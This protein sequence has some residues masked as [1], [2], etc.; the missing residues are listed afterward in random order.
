VDAMAPTVAI[1]RRLGGGALVLSALFNW[2]AALVEPRSTETKAADV[3]AT[4]AAHTDRVLA[5]SVL[6]MIGT[7]L[8]LPAV[9]TIVHLLTPRAPKLAHIGGA[10]AIAGLFGFM[11][12]HVLDAALVELVKGGA[13]REQMAALYD[14]F[15]NNPGIGL[16]VGMFLV[17]QVFGFLILSI[18]LFRTRSLPRWIPPLTWVFLL[19]DV[20]CGV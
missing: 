19:W 20:G 3:L 18:G 7:V 10:M 5:S 14:R 8:F 17:G 2:A 1:R 9:L 4:I 13:D 16:A 6:D 12:M 15:Q 11:G